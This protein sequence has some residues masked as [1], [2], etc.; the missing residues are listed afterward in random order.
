MKLALTPIEKKKLISNKI[1]TIE[2]A[3]NNEPNGSIIFGIGTKHLWD[4][5]DRVWVFGDVESYIESM[6]NVG[7]RAWDYP[8]NTT[9]DQSG[10]CWWEC[11]R[12]INPYSRPNQN[13]ISGR[14]KPLTFKI[15]TINFDRFINSEIYPNGKSYLK[16]VLKIQLSL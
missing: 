1:I 6:K 13:I 10:C 2:R 3:L 11:V 8:D 7:R 15:L 16:P 5:V 12:D 14:T 9:N 4:K